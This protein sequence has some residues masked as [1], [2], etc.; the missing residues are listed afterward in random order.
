MIVDAVVGVVVVSVAGVTG[1][2]VLSLGSGGLDAPK[3][4]IPLIA[5]E[6]DAVRRLP[7]RM[8]TRTEAVVCVC[9]CAAIGGE[10]E[11]EVVDDKGGDVGKAVVAA[12]GV[13][14]G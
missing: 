13:V 1:L 5:L 4:I 6:I 3:P 10:D 14:T 2:S 11:L 7:L 8:E 9:G 12:V